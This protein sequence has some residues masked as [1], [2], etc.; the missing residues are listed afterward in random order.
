MRRLLTALLTCVMLLTLVFGVA[1]VL[2]DKAR[3]DVIQAVTG[4]QEAEAHYINGV[5]YQWWETRWQRQPGTYIA[6]LNGKWSEA[7]RWVED[8][9]YFNEDTGWVYYTHSHYGPWIIQRWGSC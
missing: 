3:H 1:A 8:W 6:C 4:V 9:Y 2:P 5:G 7:G